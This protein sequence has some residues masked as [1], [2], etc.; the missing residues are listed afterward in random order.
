M[1][2]ILKVTL[3]TISLLLEANSS[4]AQRRYQDPDTQKWGYADD[5]WKV[6]IPAI[7]DEVQPRFDTII[8]VKKDGKMA[9]LDDKGNFRIPLIYEQIM[10]NLS[11][12]RS[13]Y[14][15]AAVTRNSKERNT[16]GMVD[17]R[18]KVILPEKFQ[19]VRAVTPDLLVGRMDG[20]SMLQFFNL[21]GDL[22]YKIAGKSVEPGRVDDTCFEVNCLD[23]HTRYVKLDGTWVYPAE[24]RSGVWTDGRLTIL[25]RDGK[26]GAINQKGGTVIPFEFYTIVPGFDGQFIVAKDVNTVNAGVLDKNG[27]VVI[28]VGNQSILALDGVYS[29]L[30]ISTEKYGIYGKKGEVILPTKYHFWSVHISESNFWTIENTINNTGKNIFD[31]RPERYISASLVEDG[32]QFLI[33]KDGKIIRP[34]GSTAVRY[35]SEKHPFI[36]EMRPDS[37]GK[38]PKI[39][40]VGR[41]GKDLT[42]ANYERLDFTMNPRIMVASTATLEANQSGFLFLDSLEKSVLDM[43]FPNKMSNGYFRVKDGRNFKLFSPEIK[44]MHT[45]E[46]NSLSEPNRNRFE[47]FRA[48]KTTTG[49]LVAAGF[50]QGMTYGDWIGV[51]DEGKTF[52]FKKQEEPKVELKE[53][54]TEQLVEVEEFEME[55]APS[56]VERV[57]E[58]PPPGNDEVYKVV[59][60]P[61]VF[62]G[63]EPA[64]LK[65]LSDNLKY[66]P[67]AMENAIQGKVVIQFI[68]EKDGSL[69]NAQIVRDIGGGCGQEALRLVQ[70]MP[71]WTQGKQRGRTVRVEYTL[72]IAFKLEK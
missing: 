47:R 28:P 33:R 12:F 57:V 19:Y 16:W 5:E 55:E 10:P 3:I 40:L 13:Q 66:P 17:A 32:I 35:F 60:Q 4:S 44:L 7:Y 43:P 11:P 38:M 45:G 61:P 50:Q 1:N 69:S 51:N 52:M 59:E 15:Y 22:L 20:D 24:P 21:K 68:I 56:P 65:Y 36:V 25:R 9:A 30:D 71:K 18:G 14:G 63:G 64:M 54:A 62:P 39:K 53:A 31:S 37:V 58:A 6:I 72:P 2:L 41:D 26:M 23:H 70:V 46:Y 8:A 27:K 34:E 48:D 42:P 29:I 49:R 67:I